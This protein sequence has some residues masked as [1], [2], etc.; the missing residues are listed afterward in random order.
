MTSGDSTDFSRRDHYF[1][2]KYWHGVARSFDFSKEVRNQGLLSIF[3]F[4]KLF[5]G[6]ILFILWV[7]SLKSLSE[8]IF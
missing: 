2:G 8:H 1:M 3:V 7:V 6:Q 4:L 5:T